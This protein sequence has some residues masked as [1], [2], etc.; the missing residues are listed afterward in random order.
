M[1]TLTTLLVGFCMALV[2][3]GCDNKPSQPQAC[4]GVA[5]IK[6]PDNQAC[7]DDPTDTCDPAR[8]GRDCPGICKAE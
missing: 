3:A 6:C 7:V 5:G 2:L 8:G 4:G 1:N